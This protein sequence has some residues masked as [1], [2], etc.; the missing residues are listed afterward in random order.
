MARLGYLE[1]WFADAEGNALVGLTVEIR[2]RGA[3]A[4][5]NSGGVDSTA[6]VCHHPGEIVTGDDCVIDIGT[7]EQ[8]ATV[9]S[10]TSITLGGAGLTW[11][12]GER[13]SP[14]TDLP[15]LFSDGESVD[16]IA[17]P[18]TT[19][20]RGRVQAYLTSGYYDMR[21][22]G[23][24]YTTTLMFDVY[25]PL[26]NPGDIRYADQFAFTNSTTEGIQEAI[27]DLPDPDGGKVVLSAKT[28]SVSN[29][30]WLRTGVHLQGQG[31]GNTIVK[32][33]T[34]SIADV[35][36]NNT[37]AT[38][39]VSTD[40]AG[41]TLP[42][43]ST[44][45]TNVSISD[46]TVDGNSSNFGALT[47]VNLHVDGIRTD[48]VDGIYIHNV[49]CQNILGNGYYIRH[50]KN[51]VMDHV[52]MNKCGQ[53]GITASANGISLSTDHILW[54]GP[55]VIDNFI[56]TEQN[57]LTAEAIAAVSPNGLA[58]T[59]GRVDDCDMFLEMEGYTL[60]GSDGAD[61]QNVVCSNVTCTNML[62]KA[63]VL[64]T[65]AGAEF[66]NVAI[67]NISFEGHASSHDNRAIIFQAGSSTEGADNVH[68]SNCHFKNL[69]TKDTSSYNMID[70]QPPTGETVSNL[71][72]TNC[73]FS[74]KSGSTSTGDTGLALRGGITNFRMSHVLF[75]DVAGVGVQIFDN[76]FAAT[77][78]QVKLTDVVVD[79]ANADGYRVRVD[80]AASTIKEVTFSGCVAKD[81][82]KQ[83]NDAGFRI[84]EGFAGSTI[85]R[86]VYNN[87]RSYK[88]SGTSHE[89]GLRVV[90]AAG[91]VDNITVSDC[92]FSDTQTD[93]FVTSG[94]ITNMKF[95][96]PS[97]RG[98]DIASAATIA[99]PS[100][101]DVFH[102]TG[103]TNIT[104]G[105]TVNDWDNGRQVVLIFDDVLT[106]SNTG[107]SNLAQ[108]YTSVANS[109]L[110]LKC[111]GTNWNE[112]GSS[113]VLSSESYSVTSS[114]L[115]SIVVDVDT[116]APEVGRV[117]ATLI[118]DLQAIGLIQ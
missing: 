29:T 76:L 43:I 41:G 60:S 67:S 89:Y 93:W 5:G 45:Q 57:G 80:N 79:G 48:F 47:N 112:S 51:L 21:V 13:L 110:A 17:N 6:F 11:I 74:G 30:V 33:A 10:K 3:R 78:S 118:T 8:S 82:A 53:W 86:I 83:V 23:T 32:R 106:V 27:D 36:A 16:S 97:D 81:C 35:D 37:G 14:T 117:L 94:T 91:T 22:S 61:S 73:S 38:I 72:F 20:S 58:I 54:R 40:G 99:I 46:L 63:F 9:N 111:D 87:C 28:Y 55:A 39:G 12:D 34:G 62:D 105:I 95:R 42:T 88:T 92:D 66:K 25:V 102:V 108:D 26:E 77:I 90:Q 69:N 49:K 98:T 71:S 18:L 50:Y 24:G 70:I 75:K 2:K 107:T 65:L 114:T 59:N 96:A 68:F 19:D 44:T 4:N 84:L 115:R 15:A 64:T 113:M 1:K 31:I 52:H 109:V 56:I 7:S 104:N 116:E 100:D 103:T 101:G 85:Q